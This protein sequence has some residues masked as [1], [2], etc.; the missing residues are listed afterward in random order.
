[1]NVLEF[2]Q[3][4]QLQCLILNHIIE[5]TYELN[6]KTNEFW[7]YVKT[8]KKNWDSYYQNVRALKETFSSL[9]KM[10]EATRKTKNSYEKTLR[11]INVLWKSN[12][13]K[14]TRNQFVQ[15]LRSMRRCVL[16]SLSLN[17]VRRV[18]SLRIKNRLMNFAKE[19]STNRKS[20]NKNWIKMTNEKID[21]FRI[22]F[23]FCLK[24]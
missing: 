15:L 12:E 22:E 13:K 5:K 8:N 2:K 14:F 17:D 4:Y 21:S 18:V 23:A 16:R 3:R 9:S 11:R 20:I 7:H 24:S 6:I 10:I 19:M 1:M